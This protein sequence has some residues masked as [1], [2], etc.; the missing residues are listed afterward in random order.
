MLQKVQRNYVKL[1]QVLIKTPPMWAFS[2]SKKRQN[3]IFTKKI[4]LFDHVLVEESWHDCYGDAR[5][6]AVD[7]AGD[8]FIFK[9]D[10]V[11]TVHFQQIVI[12]KQAITSCR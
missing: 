5:A 6:S 4:L 8:F 7:N 1:G 2:K 11:L 9:P 3:Q 10:Y 12:S